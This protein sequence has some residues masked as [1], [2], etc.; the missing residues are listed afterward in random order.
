V[1]HDPQPE[2]RSACRSDEETEHKETETTMTVQNTR[3]IVRTVV[4]SATAV[5]PD[6]DLTPQER[7]HLGLDTATG[8]E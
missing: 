1:D 6:R 2:S 7:E 3:T 5:H 8:K 4:A